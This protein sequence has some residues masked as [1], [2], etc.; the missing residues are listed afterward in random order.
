MKIPN[1]Y[2]VSVSHREIE[3]TFVI[4]KRKLERFFRLNQHVWDKH[5][6][7]R[8]DFIVKDVWLKDTLVDEVIVEAFP[9]DFL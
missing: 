2:F 1:G 6:L 9:E 7:K 5:K 4:R 3:S 8:K